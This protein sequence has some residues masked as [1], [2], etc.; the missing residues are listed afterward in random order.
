[1]EELSNEQMVKEQWDLAVST[2]KSENRLKK[3]GE[4]NAPSV[5]VEQEIRIL[6]DR[7]KKL[8]GIG[9]TLI[10]YAQ[11]YENACDEREKKLDA[12]L[13]GVFKNSV[14]DLDFFYDDIQTDDHLSSP[15]G[16]N[17]EEMNEHWRE[18]RKGIENGNKKNAISAL[19]HICSIIFADMLW[20]K[21]P[22][23]PT[24]LDPI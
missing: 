7:K 9:D 17:E 16:E 22:S 6:S 14:G 1:M 19:W 20:L 4:L 12:S 21:M 23:V 3:M 8:N 10:P 2:Q 5:I 11:N 15:F 18:F 24:P 13:L